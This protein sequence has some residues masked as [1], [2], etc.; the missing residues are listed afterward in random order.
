MC[1]L[2]VLTMATSYNEAIQLLQK[3]PLSAP[4][5]YITA[6][7]QPN[8]GA[9]LTRDRNFLTDLWPLNVSSS[10]PNS[11]YLLETNY[12]S[13]VGKIS[14]AMAIV[15]RQLPLA[16]TSFHIHRED[17]HNIQTASE[18]FTVMHVTWYKSCCTLFMLVSVM[19]QLG[20]SMVQLKGSPTSSPV[21]LYYGHYHW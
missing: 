6:G 18:C 8:E 1:C 7:S 17:K 12:V 16:V 2:Q 13:E 3:E 20:Q 21:P 9:V 19:W 4:V 15:G 5:Y 11:W 14:H 10:V